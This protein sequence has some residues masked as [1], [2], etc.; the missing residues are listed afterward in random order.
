[1][2]QLQQCRQRNQGVISLLKSTAMN[3]IEHPTGNGD[4]ESFG[5]LNYKT[6]LVESVQGTHHFD[7]RSVKGMMS[8]MDL[9]KRVFVSS[10]MIPYAIPMPPTSSKQ[11]ST[12]GLSNDTWAMHNW[13]LP[14]SISTSPKRARRT[15]AS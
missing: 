6:L 8:V 10:V 12:C 3:R 1:M 11:E 4:L 9:L 7:F 14:C 5:E 13:N 15:P 2:R